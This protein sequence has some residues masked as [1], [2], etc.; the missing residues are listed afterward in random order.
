[1]GLDMFA[2]TRNG[3]LPAATDFPHLETDQELHYWRKHP[4]L[5]GW[6][7]K[8]YYAKGGKA[9]S[10]NCVHVSLTAEDLDRLEADI[11]AGVL[12]ETIGF[13]FGHSHGDET[14]DDLYFI[15]KARDAIA[16]GKS[17]YYSSW[18]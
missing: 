10:F 7:Q 14:P 18:W 17:V 4:N 8:L 12:P 13:F 2:L 3:T 1:M 5:H 9:E 11:Q 16:N 15:A 6:M